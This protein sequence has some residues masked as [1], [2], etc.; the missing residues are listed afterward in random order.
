M[1]ELSFEEQMAL[2]D[3]LVDVEQKDPDFFNG[4]AYEEELKA[5]RK[6]LEQNAQEDE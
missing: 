1:P 4:V 5:A 2:L 6:V 3:A